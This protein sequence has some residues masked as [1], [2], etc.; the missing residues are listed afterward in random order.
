MT[1]APETG[2]INRLHF[3]TPVSATCVIETG[4]RFIWYQIPAPIR[5]LLYSEPESGV[6]VT[7]LM[8]YDW[9][10]TTAYASMFFLVAI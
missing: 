7:E 10:T 1:H 3:L 5:T 6:H 9:L 2:V 8:T 4:I